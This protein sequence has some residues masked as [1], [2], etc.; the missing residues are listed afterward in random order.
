MRNTASERR[1]CRE[2][3]ITPFCATSDRGHYK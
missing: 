1:I 3:L 2:V